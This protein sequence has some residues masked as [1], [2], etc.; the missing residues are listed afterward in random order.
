MNTN[1]N[2]T[3][4]LSWW[5]SLRNTNLCTNR[6]KD[7]GYYSNKYFPQRMYQYL[8]NDEILII[9]TSINK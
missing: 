6:T 5:D 8:T 3:I 9:Y 7:K 4:A 2:I 1:Q